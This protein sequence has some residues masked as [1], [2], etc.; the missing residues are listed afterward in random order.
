MLKGLTS[1]DKKD[2]F[3][4]YSFSGLKN[5]Q[6]ILLSID[7]I[8]SDKPVFLELLAC[9]GGC[10]NGPGTNK[11][12][13]AV[14]KQ[15][16]VNLTA[17]KRK[18]IKPDINSVS[19]IQNYE[20][21]K[22]PEKL[23]SESDVK[24]VFYRIGKYHKSDELDCGACGYDTC[25]DC[26]IAIIKEK[27]E[28]DMCVSYLRKLAQN[29]INALF[30]TMPSA[31]VIVNKDLQ[32]VE[33]NENFL[34][35]FD[36]KEKLAIHNPQD[37]QGAELSRIVQFYDLFEQVL[38]DH[39]DIINQIYEIDNKVLN[40]SIFTIE[41]HYLAGAVIQDVTHSSH[42]QERIISN[43]KKVITK[44]LDMA[45]KIAYLLGENVAEIETALS[46]IIETFDQ[47]KI[48][49]EK[50]PLKKKEDKDGH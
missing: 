19:Y 46:N 18:E 27:A 31:V 39:E 14:R 16:K 13:A 9:E 48:N 49:Q 21:V 3:Y 2:D 28:P 34:D 10:V 24:N 1:G 37:F 23:I 25:R 6:N 47:K 22:V 41:E 30:K 42:N 15:I 43:A 5:I 38:L 20:T 40:L 11:K 26:A 50:I 8:K 36:L 44:N 12:N 29:K 35:L 32:V 17:E 4:Y 7:D 33:C 45:S